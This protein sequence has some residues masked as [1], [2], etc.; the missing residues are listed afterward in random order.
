MWMGYL[1]FDENNFGFVISDMILID[2]Q[3]KLL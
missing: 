1:N 3:A 2:R